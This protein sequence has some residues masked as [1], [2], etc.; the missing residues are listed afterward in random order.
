MALYLKIIYM[1]S[2]NYVQVSYF[3]YKVYN[4]LVCWS[5][6]TAYSIQLYTLIDYAY[7]IALILS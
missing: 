6:I 7:F 2:R 1:V 3:L 4:F 5:T